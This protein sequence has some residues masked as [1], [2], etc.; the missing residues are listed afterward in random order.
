[1]RADKQV[2]RHRDRETDR[3]TDS[4]IAILCTP[5]GAGEV[6][7]IRRTRSFFIVNTFLYEIERGT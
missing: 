7:I 2:E 4:L 6:I 1:M 3:H 5:T